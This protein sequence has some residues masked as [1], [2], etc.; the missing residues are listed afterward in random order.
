R[1]PEAVTLQP[2]QDERVDRVP[3]VAGALDRRDR[4]T[5]NGPKR[6]P[7]EPRPGFRRQL[8]GVEDA[9]PGPWRSSTEP[10][11]ED[12]LFLLGQ[13]PRLAAFP[14]R[15]LAGRDALEQATGLR[16]AGDDD[17]P[18]RAAGAQPLLCR[19]VEIALRSAGVVTA[20]AATQQHRGNG[21]LEV[22]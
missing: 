7:I 10:G 12:V 13:P 17:G 4:R 20:G 15:H 2:G 11:A 8:V 5:P 1:R 3:R 6:P 9:A 14:G 22:R 19:Q 21:T 16:P 18:I